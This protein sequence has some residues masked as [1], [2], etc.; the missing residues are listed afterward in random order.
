MGYANP[1]MSIS[2]NFG[3]IDFGS[4]GSTRIK[5]PSGRKGR[6]RDVIVAGNT[7]FTAVTT[8]AH[9]KLGTAGTAGAYFDMTM[10][11]LA[12]DAT[13]VASK[14]QAAAFISRDL[15]VDTDIKL[16]FTAPTGGSPAG[17][18]YVTVQ[19]DWF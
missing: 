3:L 13:Q 15:P 14:D 11:T 9:V 7:L 6:L 10:G 18:G 5:G 17:K 4:D 19:I 1:N 12:A 2:Y 8:P 16:N